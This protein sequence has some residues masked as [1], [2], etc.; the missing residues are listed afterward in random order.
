M[1]RLGLLL[2]F[3]ALASLVIAA[4]NRQLIVVEL[5][6]TLGIGNYAAALLLLTFGALFLYIGSRSGLRAPKSSERTSKSSNIA[7]LRAL[8]ILVAVGALAA[9]GLYQVQK[10]TER[11]AKSP[12]PPWTGPTLFRPRYGETTK[13]PVIQK[14]SENETVNIA[15]RS[16][17]GNGGFFFDAIL[18][19]SRL[20]NM[21][22]V[23]AEEILIALRP[24]LCG[25]SGFISSYGLETYPLV[26]SVTLTSRE[27][28][29]INIPLGY[30]IQSA[31]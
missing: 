28:Y 29:I 17:A 25:P 4:F 26:F 9:V 15:L 8:L 30:C 11:Q 6:E 12:V 27:P 3:V 14:I 19:S 21:R 13:W 5:L 20:D 10:N 22:D 18:K 23:K 2:I 16:T 24:G 1:R 31:R 7:A